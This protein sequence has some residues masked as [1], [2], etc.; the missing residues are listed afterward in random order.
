MNFKYVFKK[1]E[2][3]KN[4]KPPAGFELETYSFV[5]IPLTNCSMLSY[6]NFEKLFINLYLILLFIS[7]NNMSQH[8]VDPYHP[9]LAIS[10]TKNKGVIS[11]ENTS[12]WIS[13]TAEILKTLCECKWKQNVYYQIIGICFPKK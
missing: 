2:K 13:D 9:K 8:E 7:I 3:V 11:Q 1:F 4:L 6:D 5:V 12:R 10:R